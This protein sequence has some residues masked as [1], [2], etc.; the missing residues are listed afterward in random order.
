MG[1]WRADAAE[2][3]GV[4]LWKIL[5]SASAVHPEPR[6]KKGGLRASEAAS[7]GTNKRLQS[8]ALSHQAG[9]LC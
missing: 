9:G 6:G 1:G 3:I 8:L 2:N 5:E 7:D 4:K